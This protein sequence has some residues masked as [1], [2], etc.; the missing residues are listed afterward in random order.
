MQIAVKY[1]TGGDR[2]IDA[3]GRV[4]GESVGPVLVRR[5]LRL[6]APAILIGP[7]E[8]EAAGYRVA[9]LSSLDPEDTLVINMD[10]IDSAGVW[11][12]L[13]H[14]ANDPSRP[15]PTLEPKVMN[16]VWWNADEEYTHPKEQALLGVAYALFPTFANSERTASEVRE[17]LQRWTVPDLAQRARIA[18]SNLGIRLERVQPRRETKVPVVLY[19]AIYVSD[20]K[21]PWRFIDVVERVASHTRIQVHMRLHEAHLASEPAMHLS[22]HDWAWV[23]PLTATREG[24]WAKLAETTAFLATAID[25]SYGLEYIE[26][27]LAGVV[28]VFPDTSWA[29]AILPSGYPFRY[30][31]EQEAERMLRRAVTEPEACRAD[32]DE[33][34]GGSFVEWIGR[35]HDDHDFEDALRSHV[36]QWFG[37]T[38]RG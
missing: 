20:R 26:A 25:E 21:K 1:T 5:L 30:T 7:E 8:K 17:I 15:T 13:R 36:E 33:C 19:P 11:S 27:M 16:F 10:V 18:W 12:Y 37:P 6:F 2:L 9:P 24:Y 4:I 35:T 23:G 31:N 14:S 38:G 34:V 28:G 29:R 3:E 32:L 22:Q